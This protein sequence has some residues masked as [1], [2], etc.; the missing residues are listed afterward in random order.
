[1]ILGYENVSQETKIQTK[2][3]YKVCVKRVYTYKKKDCVTLVTTDCCWF[4][5]LLYI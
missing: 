3:N 1:M 4:K 5:K 2:S